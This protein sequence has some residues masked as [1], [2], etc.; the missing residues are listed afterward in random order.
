MSEQHVY[1]QVMKAQGF[2]IEIEHILSNIFECD[3]LGFGG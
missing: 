1:D 2:A 3:R